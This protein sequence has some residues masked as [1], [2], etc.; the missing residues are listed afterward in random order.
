MSTCCPGCV[1][2]VCALQEQVDEHIEQD[3]AEDE[4]DEATELSGEEEDQAHQH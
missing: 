3:E 2:A 1:A 4:E